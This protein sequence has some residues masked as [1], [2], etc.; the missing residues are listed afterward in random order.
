MIYYS[1][2]VAFWDLLE[3]QRRR[4]GIFSDKINEKKHAAIISNLEKKFQCFIRNFSSQFN[5]TDR[6]QGPIPALIWICWWDGIPAMP[7]LVRACFNSVK[8][9]SGIYKVMLVTRNNFHDFVSIPDYLLKKLDSGI[10]TKTHFSDILRMTL[11]ARHGGIWLD[12]SVLVTN[13]IL[14]VNAPFF[15]IKKEYGG[16]DVPRRRWTIFCIGG[17]K[18]NILFLF[19]KDFFYEYLK[20][21]DYMIDYY[22]LDYVIAVGYR[23]IPQI[24]QMIDGTCLNNPNLYIMQENLGSEFN[25]D[26]FNSACKDT[27]FHKLTWK[28]NYPAVA[29]GN[30]LTLYG[31]I[32]DR[33]AE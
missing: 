11:L 33:Y 30:K 28:K 14:P 10:I 15:T 4:I 5:G 26:F 25:L 8:K 1:F 2:P 17:E 16:E 12:A 20:K 21:N 19:A 9:N 29:A 18:N 22:L 27:I 23:S 32:M 6:F 7:P 3:S 13:T 31:Y 24:K